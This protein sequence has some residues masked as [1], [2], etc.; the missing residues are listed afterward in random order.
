MLKERIRFVFLRML[1]REKI[2]EVIPYHIVLHEVYSKL[3][4]ANFGTEPCEMKEYDILLGNLTSEFNKQREN[5]MQKK[6]EALEKLDFNILG[7]KFTDE[8]KEYLKDVIDKKFGQL[9]KYIDKQESIAL[10]ILFE[11]LK[12]FL[13]QEHF[14]KTGTDFYSL[15]EKEEELKRISELT[16]LHN[17]QAL[18]DGLRANYF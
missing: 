5:L 17:N 15:E 8:E 16:S 10:N 6:N 4:Y 18:I 3:G 7:R 12:T 2:L 9:K 1:D 14:E 11:D 13:Y